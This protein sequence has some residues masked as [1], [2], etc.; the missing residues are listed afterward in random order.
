[1]ALDELVAAGRA[2]LP[3]HPGQSLAD[4][5]SLGHD[6]L[7][8]KG[9]PGREK[10]FSYEA[11]PVRSPRQGMAASRPRPEGSAVAR[12]AG[13]ANGPRRARIKKSARKG[14]FS[15][16]A[17]LKWTALLPGRDAVT[18]LVQGKREGVDLLELEV[19][20]L[21]DAAVFV[22]ALEVVLVDPE[23]EEKSLIGRVEFDFPG[24]LVG[25]DVLAQYIIA[26]IVVVR[27]GHEYGVDSIAG[28]IDEGKVKD[29]GEGAGSKDRSEANENQKL[30]HTS[31]LLHEMLKSYRSLSFFA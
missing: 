23:S 31:L 22:F 10:P 9:V 2:L 3:G 8:K 13:Y 28:L 17:I 14:A 29:R 16:Q 15:V 24:L 18:L 1:V 4:N 6:H 30:L 11:T 19:V 20:P 7:S 12:L 26:P 21:V 5:P 27:G 25:E